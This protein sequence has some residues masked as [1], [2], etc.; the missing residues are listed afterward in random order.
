MKKDLINKLNERYEAAMG[1]PYKDKVEKQL[2]AR[3][4]GKNNN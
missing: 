4:R 1:E 3:F 2:F